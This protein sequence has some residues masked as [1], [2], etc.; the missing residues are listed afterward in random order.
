MQEINVSGINICDGNLTVALN[1]RYVDRYLYSNKSVYTVSHRLNDAFLNNRVLV[2]STWVKNPSL[3][4]RN[5][6][7]QKPS[8]YYRLIKTRERM[9]ICFTKG[10]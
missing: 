4:F 3:N 1:Q 8:H 7:S 5:Q 2:F 9:K 6:L 10:V